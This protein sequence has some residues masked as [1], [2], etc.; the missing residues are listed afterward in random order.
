MRIAI[1]GAGGLVGSHA[2]RFFR[3]RGHTAITI[4]RGGAM[5]IL[6]DAADPAA[7]RAALGKARPDAV[8]NAVKSSMKTD[9]AETRKGDAWLSNVAAAE[10]IAA[11][12]GKLGAKLVHISSAWV[13]EGRDG[14]TYSE[15]SITCP[16]N[17][18]AYT[19]A[20]S[21]ERALRHAPDALVLRP[22]CVFGKDPRGADFFSRLKAASEKGG[23]F[24]AADGQFSQPIFAGEIARLSEALL[25]SGASGIYNCVGPDYLS[26]HALALRMCSHFG[27]DPSIVAD[28]PGAARKI[29]VPSFL[30][31]DISKISSICKV[32]GIGEQL[33]DLEK[34]AV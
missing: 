17:F 22:D 29:R 1:F 4:G 33:S 9:L 21:E 11:A 23:E 30:R 19:K 16:V 7:V 10:N 18:Y 6:A 8:L 15:G 28:A 20:I 31:L 2:A 26:R 14:E 3:A 34:E 25:A 24:P 32:R 5:D 12:S 13:Y 27:F